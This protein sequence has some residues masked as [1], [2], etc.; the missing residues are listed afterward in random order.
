MIS[1]NLENVLIKDESG[2]K[3][4]PELYAVPVYKVEEEYRFPHSQDRVPLGKLPHTWGQSLYIISKLLTD[5]LIAPGEID[6]LNKR[7]VIQPKPDLVVQICVLMEDEQVQQQ[8]FEDHNIYLETVSSISPVK[9]YPSKAL[10]HLYSFLGKNDRL[11]L[12][13]RPVT[14]IGYLA[15]AKLY[16]I[17]GQIMAFTPSVK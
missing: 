13:G 9:I 17:K 5:D 4:V 2:I 12:T 11:G 7:L 1:A 10:A 3:Q 14:D 15:T 6:P 8:I 16:S